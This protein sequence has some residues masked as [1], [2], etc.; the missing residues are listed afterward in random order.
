M[1][2]KAAMV[3]NA[4]ELNKEEVI[5]L[6]ENELDFDSLDFNTISVPSFFEIM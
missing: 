3:I 4:L 5:Y 1:S 6:Q 2:Q